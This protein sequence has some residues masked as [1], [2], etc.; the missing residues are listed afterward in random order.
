[1]A[2]M[3]FQAKLAL[4]R[5]ELRAAINVLAKEERLSGSPGERRAFEFVREFLESRGIESELVEHP[6]LVG[7]PIDGMLSVRDRSFKLRP[8][9]MAP[10][11][12]GDGVSAEIVDVGAG[13]LEDFRRI[14]VHGKIVLASGLPAPARY[15]IAEQHGAIGQL[16]ALE[17]RFHEMIVSPVWGTATEETSGLLPKTPSA[18]ILEEDAQV[19]REMM[20]ESAEPVTMRTEAFLGWVDIPRL[21]ALIPG[22]SEDYVL[23]SSHIDSWHE[24]AIDN[25]TGNLGVL[26]VAASLVGAPLKRGLKIAFWSGHSHGRY[27]GSAYFVDEA[28]D[29]LEAR[30]V[31]HVNLD[32]LGSANSQLFEAIPVMSP[33]YQFVRE[34]LRE[35]TGVELARRPIPR[36][37]D[38]SLMGLGVP[39]IFNTL[40]EQ[41][42]MGDPAEAAAAAIIGSSGTGGAGLGWFW[43]S[44]YDLVD[45]Y[46]DDE[47][48]RDLEFVLAVCAGICT[49][50][51][52]PWRFSDQLEETIQALDGLPGTV[53]DALG[54]A[55]VERN[56]AALRDRL[57]LREHLNWKGFDAVHVDRTLKQLGHSLIPVVYSVKGRYDQDLALSTPLLPGLSDAGRLEH[58]QPGTAE[59]QEL[60]ITKLRQRNRLASALRESE[61]ALDQLEQTGKSG[62]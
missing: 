46:G 34:I 51:V 49:A 18:S 13:T 47:M 19:L 52:L 12:S 16:Y 3:M 26:G 25:G 36:A 1:M 45:R 33:A 14:D 61:R 8:H 27:A 15:L 28:W 31:A 59:Y 37:G 56:A 48:V 53:T 7:Y 17:K 35:Q 40:S 4:S 62:Q 24:G 55:E 21:T 9:A 54:L 20:R 39:A 57:I 50:E 32:G 2:D 22:E 30:C 58:L 11:T 44:I 42:A 38:H 29:D 23:L 43:H 10:S 41:P 5:E 60:L 6:A